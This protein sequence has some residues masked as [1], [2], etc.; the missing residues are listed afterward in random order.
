MVRGEG[1]ETEIV[2]ELETVG[3]EEEKGR[4]RMDSKIDIRVE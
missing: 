1:A 2:D 4:Q 3:K